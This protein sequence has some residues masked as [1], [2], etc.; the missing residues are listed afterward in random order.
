MCAAFFLITMSVIGCLIH[1]VPMLT[2]RGVS[3]RNAAFAT[4]LFGG[5]LIIG[6]VG[7]GYLLDRFFASYVAAFLF[8]GAGLGILLLWSGATGGAAFAAAFLV[9]M[10][11]GAEGDIIT[12]QVG[13]YFGLRAFGEIYGYILITY[14]LGG[15]VG[16]LLM[17]FGFDA[18][19][20]YSFVLGTFLLATIG[21]AGLMMQLGPYRAWEAS[22][23]SVAA[24]TR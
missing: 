4:S 22:D 23:R 6:R 14:T 7:T 19:G 11:V 5:A 1:L 9:G 24:S 12:Y 13:R 17:G 16:P 21:A 18:T 2:D 3:A 8:V 15:M 10:G 20:S